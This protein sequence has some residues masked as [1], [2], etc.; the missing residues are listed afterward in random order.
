MFDM[1]EL[2]ILG[3]VAGPHGAE[4]VRV[5]GAAPQAGDRSGRR[6][7]VSGVRLGLQQSGWRP[8]TLHPEDGHSAHCFNCEVQQQRVL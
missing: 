6:L 4:Q 5:A 1:F 3:P 7:A 8:G 2:L